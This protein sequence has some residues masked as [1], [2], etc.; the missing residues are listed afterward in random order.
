MSKYTEQFK[1]GAISAYLE[2]TDGFRKVAQHFGIDFSLLRRWVASFRAHSSASPLPRQRYSPDFK[3][4][5]VRY[6]RENRLSLRQTAAHFGLGQ[7][8]Q[9]GIW[10][11]QYYS[12]VVATPV[13]TKRMPADVTKKIKPVKPT[14]LDDALKPREQLMAELEYLRMENAVLKE[15]KAL[16]QEKERR[17]AKKR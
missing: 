2:G 16:E 11:H 13:A 6:M 3:R 17:R 10:E 7:S 5:V 1:L 15:L 9:I 14:D 8:S 4:K 12:G